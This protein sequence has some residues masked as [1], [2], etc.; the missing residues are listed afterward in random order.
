MAAGIAAVEDPGRYLSYL[1]Y[2]CAYRVERSNPIPTLCLFLALRNM[3]LFKCET[4]KLFFTTYTGS[5]PLV[6]FSILFLTTY[7]FVKYWPCKLDLE[8][9]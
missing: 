3:R 9:G 6:A 5:T 7:A 2:L 8:W 4:S 1:S